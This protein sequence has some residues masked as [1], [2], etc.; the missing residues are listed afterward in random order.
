M[1]K[2][3]VMQVSGQVMAQF[4]AVYLRLTICLSRTAKRLLALITQTYR[5][6][7]IRLLP[8]VQIVL[9]FKAWVASLITAA[10][11][12]KRVL[13]TAKRRLIQTGSQLRTTVRQ[14]RQ[15]AKPPR[16][17]GK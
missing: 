15:R 6:V 2:R 17:K 16:K 5:N 8:L 11:L 10:Q 14:I 1:L 13:I 12:I 7:R 9:S 3:I 4:T